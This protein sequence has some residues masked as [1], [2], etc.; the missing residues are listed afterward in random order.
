[1]MTTILKSIIAE[2]FVL[3][4]CTEIVSENCHIIYMISDN[5]VTKQ[6]K[7]YKFDIIRHN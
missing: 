2:I 1:M 7:C 3:S 6:L 4:L 5:I